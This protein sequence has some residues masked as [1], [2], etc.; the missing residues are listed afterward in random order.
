[1]GVGLRVL[2]GVGVIVGVRVGGEVI[3][4]AGVV[5]WV[6]VR[7]AVGVS[8]MDAGTVGVAVVSEVLSGWQLALPSKPIRQININKVLVGF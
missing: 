8:V 4:K 5:V 6:G 7:V 1:V 2:K 3:V